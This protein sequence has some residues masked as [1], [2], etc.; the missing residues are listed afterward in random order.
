MLSVALGQNTCTALAPVE[1]FARFMEP[2]IPSFIAVS[3]GAMGWR[4]IEMYGLE[5]VHFEI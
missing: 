4:G 3:T 1:C 2:Y 5:K